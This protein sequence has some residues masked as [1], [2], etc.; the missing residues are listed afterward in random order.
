MILCNEFELTIKIN[1]SKY[2]SR[3]N[4]SLN[5]YVNKTNKFIF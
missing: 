4:D 3:M 1:Y 2:K 5:R